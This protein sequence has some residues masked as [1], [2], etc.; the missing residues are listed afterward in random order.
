M[1]T[2]LCEILGHSHIV[3]RYSPLLMGHNWLNRADRRGSCGIL[4]GVMDRERLQKCP[5]IYSLIPF[6]VKLPSSGEEP[7][8]SH[9]NLSIWTGELWCFVGFFYSW[10]IKPQSVQPT[11]IETAK[12]KSCCEVHEWWYLSILFHIFKV[13]FLCFY[14]A[15]IKLAF[16]KAFFF[17]LLYYYK[18]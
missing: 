9:L 6:T 18:K 12:I 14:K 13:L 2:P 17:F 3:W 16:H 10:Q 15:F 1:K 5:V 4:G 7:E 11:A 8:H